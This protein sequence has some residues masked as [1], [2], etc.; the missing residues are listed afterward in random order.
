[1]ST[2]ASLKELGLSIIAVANQKGG[3]GKTASV[4]AL[5]SGLARRG[6][7]VLI[8][9]GDP[10][11][12]LSLHFIPVS[13][14]EAS[15]GAPLKDLGY[16]LHQLASGESSTLSLLDEC[17][18]KR[19]K[20]RLDLLPI[21]QRHLRTELGDEGIHRAGKAFAVLLKKLKSRYDWIIIDSSPS[22]G[23][24]E[25]LLISASEAVI[26]PLEFQIFS[27]SGL[28]AILSDT[29]ECA[30][31]SGH[32]IR[33][34]ALIITKVENSLA[35]VESY[36]KLFASFQIPIF[37]VCKSEYVSRA[38]ER[39]K[40]IWEAAPSSYVAKDY[41]RIISKAFLG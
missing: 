2:N 28:D 25:R 18:L 33:P 11:G 26:I 12:N 37:E 41:D 22:N 16:L 34:H 32:P 6:E 21:S 39:G 9:D 38:F 36:R 4:A 8:I 20:L 35:R 5:A 10:Q 7:R 19:V 1:M 24:L 40:T 17:I 31:L 29:A 14:V 27:M 3:V 30:E 13:R 15:K 23:V